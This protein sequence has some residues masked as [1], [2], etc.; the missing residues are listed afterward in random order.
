[1]MLQALLFKG[2]G[3]TVNV[4]IS[5]RVSTPHQGSEDTIQLLVVETIKVRF[6]SRFLAK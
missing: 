1:M 5:S 3:L 6:V 2:D 4:D